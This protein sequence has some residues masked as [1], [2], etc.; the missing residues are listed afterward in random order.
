MAGYISWH[1]LKF[2]VEVIA[3]IPCT[4]YIQRGAEKFSI[5]III[6][7]VQI[8]KSNVGKYSSTLP[9]NTSVRIC[10]YANQFHFS[11]KLFNHCYVVNDPIVK[12]I[13]ILSL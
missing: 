1:G 3:E 2:I 8:S 12:K 11:P 9:H 10:I 6:E 7:R 5:K 4:H 13:T